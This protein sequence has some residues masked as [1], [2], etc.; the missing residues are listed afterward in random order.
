MS[1]VSRFFSKTPSLTHLFILVFLFLIGASLWSWSSAGDSSVASGVAYWETQ[2]REHG[3]TNAYALFAGSVAGRRVAV[4]HDRAHLFGEA[5]YN[6]EGLKGITACDDRFL[7][8]CYHALAATAVIEDGL[9][10]ARTMYDACTQALGSAASFCHHGVGHGLLAG[11]GYDFKSLKEAL[12]ICNE[13]QIDPP[14]GGCFGGIFMEYNQQTS[15]ADAAEPRA[16]NPE[17][18]TTP[19]NQLETR[20]IRMCAFWVPLWWIDEFPRASGFTQ[21][22]GNSRVNMGNFCR[23][24]DDPIAQ[25]LCF[26]GVG[27]VIA[28]N[29]DPADIPE[30]CSEVASEERG[31]FLCQAQAAR[32]SMDLHSREVSTSACEGLSIRNKRA[33]IEYMDGDAWSD[34]I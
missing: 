24:F 7:Y 22:A 3:A 14:R 11:L 32:R 27:N 10:A 6:V 19:C 30:G 1:A 29:L 5:L 25:E 20:Y 18:V 9:S 2:I 15:L 33:C 21:L 17:S 4:Q 26:A 16:L 34:L 31:R 28:P 23:L 8:G 12:A 13:I